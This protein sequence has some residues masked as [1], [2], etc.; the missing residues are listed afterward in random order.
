MQLCGVLHEKA[1]GERED[2]SHSCGRQ[3]T[4][5]MQRYVNGE[6][7][8]LHLVYGIAEDNGQA[9]ERIYRERFP[10]RHQPHHKLFARLHQNLY[11]NGSLRNTIPVTIPVITIEY[12]KE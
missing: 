2:F 6:H 5:S 9:A 8:D 3:H 12:L 11:Y 1:G 4:K 10:D 7:A